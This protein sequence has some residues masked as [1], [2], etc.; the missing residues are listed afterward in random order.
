M[1]YER[2]SEKFTSLH[3]NGISCGRSVKQMCV[4]FYIIINI[5]FLSAILILNK[6]LINVQLR[7]SCS[8]SRYSNNSDFILGINVDK[9][10]SEQ[11][12]KTG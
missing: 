11:I 10:Y 7:I 2:E 6:D 3:S 9:K 8:L 4:S 5:L 1:V 12:P